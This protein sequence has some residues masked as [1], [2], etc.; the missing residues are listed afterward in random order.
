SSQEPM[1][2]YIKVAV[3]IRKSST[4]EY[5]KAS[6]RANYPSGTIFCLRYT[7][8]G[9]RKFETL[10]VSDY[11]QASIAAQQK[12]IALQLD[13]IN[14]LKKKP[15]SKLERTP[16]PQPKAQTQSSEFMLDVAIDRYLENVAT[17]SSKTSAG[18]RHTLKQFYA[19]TGN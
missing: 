10:S 13:A 8:H 12:S 4:R 2:M 17:K 15:E 18:Y 14:P 19:S 1:P 6:A 5:E 9:K 11:K 7:Q 3:Y 16:V